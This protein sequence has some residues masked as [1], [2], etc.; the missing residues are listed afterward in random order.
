MHN[1]NQVE[2]PISP[3]RT[4]LLAQLAETSSTWRRIDVFVLT[5]I[6]GFGVLQFFCIDR[7]TDFSGDDVFLADSGRSLLEHG[8]YG[9]NGYSE[10][11]MP[12]GLPAILGFLCVVLGYNRAVFQAAMVL[13]AVLGL[14]LTYQLLRRQTSRAVA[15]AICL[16]FVSSRIHFDLVTHAIEPCYPYFF[17]S[18]GALLVISKLDKAKSLVSRI[19]WGSAVALFVTASLLIASAAIALLGGIVASVCVGFCRDRRLALTRLKAYLAVLILGVAVEGLWMRQDHGSASAGIAAAEW[20]VPGFPQSYLSQLRVKSGNYPELGMATPGDVIVRVAKNASE[21]ANLLSRVLLRRLPQLAWMSVFVAGP[22]LLVVLGWCYSIW[23]TGGDVQDWYFV[24]YEFIYLVWPWDLEIR[25]FLPIAPLACLYLWRGCQAL[26]LLAKTKPRVVGTVWIP[27]AAILTVSAWLWMHECGFASDFRNIGLEDE[28]SLAI[29]LLSG[30]IAAWMIWAG[31][32]WL[33]PV[34]RFSRHYSRVSGVSW[35]LS[36]PIPHLLGFAAVSGL[37]VAGLALQIEIGSNPNQFSADPD[38]A[39]WIRSHTSPDAIVMARHVPTLVHYSARKVVWFPPSSN[40]QLLMEGI[41]KHRVNFVLVV[42]R[43]GSAYY[44][45]PDNDCFAPLL[46]SCPG[47]FR[48]IYQVPEFKVYQVAAIDR[49]LGGT[50][51]CFVSQGLYLENSSP[52]RD[53]DDVLKRLHRMH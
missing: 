29:W 11:N 45:P 48:L 4:G 41:V 5:L 35:I 22:L 23:R 14:V 40:P 8:F 32:G 10:T 36:L 15:A 43:E 17:S 21:H 28:F 20:P 2:Q 53:S 13:F 6:I 1:K 26:L 44:R 19:A 38:A 25:F 34:S 50:P 7:A 52:T 9:I 42:R 46:R 3:V 31:T 12:P 33:A 27:V 24:G 30:L 39:K 49:P 18:M 51:S 16:L 47:A 37:V